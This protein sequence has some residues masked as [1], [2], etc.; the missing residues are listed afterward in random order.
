MAIQF[1]RCE[2]VS[3][4]TGGNACRKAAYNKR[5]S[6]TCQNTGNLYYF[7]NREGNCY[8]EVLL[9][10]GADLKFKEAS[11]LWNAV[12]FFEKRKNSQ[13][14]KEF[15]LALPD[16]PEITY[17]DRVELTRRFA[18]K[19]FVLKGVAAQM[20]VHAP[21]EGDKNWHS[22]LLVATRR[23]SE[24]GTTFHTHKARDLDPE[25]IKGR[26]VE[27]DV[28]GEHWRDLQND[29][30]IEKGLDL[31]V[32]AIGIVPQEHLGPVR[33]RHHMNDAV[34]RADLLKEANEKLAHNP[35]A[36]LDEIVRTRAVFKG[37]D[38][39]HFCETHLPEEIRGEMVS[40][41]LDLRRVKPLYN[42][43]TGERSAY[44]TTKEVRAEEHKLMR[45]AKSVQEKSSFPIDEHIKEKVCA[46]RSL[47]REQQEA[48]TYA[49]TNDSNLKIIQ[50]RAGVG[51][52]Y[53]LTP[54]KEA[55]EQMD[56]RVIG[57]AP[58]NK[59]ARD[60]SDAGFK[61]A[62]TCHSLLFQVK[63]KRLELDDKTVLMVDEAAMMGTPLMV[64]LS[65]VAKEVGVKL[66]LT[67]DERQLPSIDRSGMFEVLANTYEAKVIST[68][69][70]QEKD[71]QRQVSEDLSN[72]KFNEAAHLLKEQGRL[73]WHDTKEEALEGIVND[74]A[75]DSLAVPHEKRFV[76]AQR[77]VDVDALNAAIREIHKEHGDIGEQ[78]YEVETNRG[79][80]CFS[81]G[82]RIQF[83]ET[84]KVQGLYNGNFGTLKLVGEEKWAV[85]LDNG[86]TVLFNPQTYR[87]LRH[88][89][90]GTIYKGQGSNFIYTYVLHDRITNRQNSYVT[91]TRQIKDLKVYLSRQ[92][93][94]DFADFVHQIGKESG[95]MAS[96]T[97]DTLADIQKKQRDPNALSHLTVMKE[98][99]QNIWTHVKDYFHNNEEFYQFTKQPDNSAK[100]I[101]QKE[102]AFSVGGRSVQD[103]A[104][105]LERRLNIH[106]EKKYE[107]L[108]DPDE[109][110]VHEK[111][112][113]RTAEIL[114]TCHEQTKQDP[115]Y[116]EVNIA[117]SRA[118]YELERTQ[119]IKEDFLYQIDMKQDV[120]P[121][122]HLRA[123][124][125]GER[126]AQIEGQLYEADLRK[127]EPTQE[128]RIYRDIALQELTSH[129]QSQQTFTE[130]LMK[131]FN[132]SKESAQRVAY[133]S[134]RHL[135][136]YGEMP[137]QSHIQRYIEIGT[138]AEQRTLDL[139]EQFKELTPYQQERVV[140]FVRRREIEHML[141]QS[142]TSPDK[143]IDS[144]FIQSQAIH[145]LNQELQLVQ[146]QL[147]KENEFNR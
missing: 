27:A 50:G 9:P 81:V 48:F 51:K 16:D 42:K 3:R 29:Y 25:V 96:L 62:M 132:L 136:K 28:W 147:A 66:I 17:A 10:A 131:D 117:I 98:K 129:K 89:Y 76:L 72:L 128:P 52:S 19:Y 34:L 141:K 80:V 35:H 94:K 41:I 58:T 1:A 109:R 63:N 124:L 119:D 114:L 120:T 108:P 144:K 118:R 85:A 57:L 33:M 139:K 121:E 87:G 14:C 102:D 5:D 110:A 7:K 83:T 112:A 71:W 53:T 69:V 55:Y 47:N 39:V 111:Q 73:V 105:I 97:F 49:T 2:Y 77:N 78:D 45:F 36:I 79:K 125:Y 90:A 15:V 24:D 100:E 116:S 130:N 142:L 13:V 101:Q 88:G 145:H 43:T 93:T 22:H 86:Q 61:E 140:E 137:P 46:E 74:Y 127:N 107:R 75:R 134:I 99:A 20:D 91:L 32:D 12:E 23:F 4:T 138:Y 103:V 70:R 135:E 8:H 113:T 59:V 67:G 65:H 84:D 106:F 146:Q 38:I 115:S 56:Y 11:V 40:R 44:F 126:L 123:Q 60:L 104:A 92:S 30:F 6:I 82:D 37:S 26:V 122:D 64:E 18:D 143:P 133:E 31:R 54:I 21:H 95:K 68:V